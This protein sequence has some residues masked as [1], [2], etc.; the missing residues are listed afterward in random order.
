MQD[1]GSRALR[2][3]KARATNVLRGWAR[4]ISLSVVLDYFVAG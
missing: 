3:R 4:L 2:A 1:V